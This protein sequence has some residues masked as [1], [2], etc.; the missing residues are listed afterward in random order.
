LL[1]DGLVV[2]DRRIERGS[3]QGIAL[4]AV[5]KELLRQNDAK[6][7]DIDLF[8]VG[9]G[10][11][12]YTGMR[13]GITAG[14]ILAMSSGVPVVG[15][16]SMDALAFK[17]HQDSTVI[18][19]GRQEQFYFCRYLAGSGKIPQRLQD[20]N[21]VDGSSLA[22]HLTPGDIIINDTGLEKYLDLSDYQ[23]RQGDFAVPSALDIGVLGEQ[24]YLESG[25]DDLHMLSPMYLRRSQAEDKWDALEKK[26]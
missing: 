2:G 17:A 12:S 7:S 1:S 18:I 5:I 9:A 13:I 4:A 8:A 20:I 10:P 24:K 23:L 21:V 26:G 3:R 22:S 14:K 19:N 6:L 15:V 11:G 25:A 16:C